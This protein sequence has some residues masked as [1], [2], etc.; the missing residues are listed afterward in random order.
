VQ[1]LPCLLYASA[2]TT[3]EE[4]SGVHCV[5]PC[6]RVAR[7]RRS[8]LRVASLLAQHRVRTVPSFPAK[9]LRAVLLKPA[10][11]SVILHGFFSLSAYSKAKASTKTMKTAIRHC[12]AHLCGCGHVGRA[13][14][15]R[16]TAFRA[17]SWC[18]RALVKAFHHARTCARRTISASNLRLTKNEVCLARQ[19]ARR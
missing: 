5:S 12:K 9:L 17:F 16:A 13:D 10:P 1:L 15:H 2:H 6:C 4:Y 14:G 8:D 11:C 18:Y 7:G 3:T 19:Q